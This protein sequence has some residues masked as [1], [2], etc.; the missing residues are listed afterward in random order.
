MS[1]TSSGEFRGPLGPNRY[2]CST[3]T[4]DEARRMTGV[5][6][7]AGA[8][9]RVPEPSYSFYRRGVPEIDIGFYP[10]LPHDLAVD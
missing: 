8:S 1:E 4:T 7:A 2:W 9:R 5:L 10:L 6:E 3:L